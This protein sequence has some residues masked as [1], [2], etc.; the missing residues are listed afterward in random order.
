MTHRRVVLIG[1]MPT[2]LV[3]AA[4]LAGCSQAESEAGYG[5]PTLASEA[6]SA[7]L[8]ET[9]ASR[10]AV[11]GTLVVEPNGCFSLEA[12]DDAGAR[13]A[14]VVWPDTAR[15]D[16]DVVVLDSGARIGQGDHLD[17]SGAY[18]DLSS[19]PHGGEA[20]SYFGSFGR[21]CDAEAVGVLLLTKVND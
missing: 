13:R 4:G 21:Y 1:A 12:S 15:Q 11:S 5:L 10:A 14:W 2:V 9:G 19:L 6:Q 18:V 16:G 7:V 3:L 8:A 20:S 17:V